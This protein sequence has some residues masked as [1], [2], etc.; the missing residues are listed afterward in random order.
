MLCFVMQWNETVIRCSVI[1]WISCFIIH[2]LMQCINSEVKSEK[3]CKCLYAM[4]RTVWSLVYSLYSFHPIFLKTAALII[5]MRKMRCWWECMVAMVMV[6][7]SVEQEKQGWHY[8]KNSCCMNISI[9][10]CAKYESWGTLNPPI[11]MQNLSTQVE[12]KIE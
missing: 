12:K 1:L 8:L 11:F 6:N 3:L 10:I 7:Y 4:F 5:K 9:W 2:V